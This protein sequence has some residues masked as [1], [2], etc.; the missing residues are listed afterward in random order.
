MRATVTTLVALLLAL[1]LFAGGGEEQ[2]AAA[3]DETAGSEPM[4][5]AGGYLEPPFLAQRVADGELPPIDERLPGNPLVLTRQ[6]NDAPDGILDYQD[7][8]YGGT[9]RMVNQHPF[10]TPVLSFM[11]IEQLLSRPGYNIGDP[12]TGNVAES[13]S[14]NDDNTEFTF[15]IREGLRWSDGTPVTTEDVRY[16][17]EDFFLNDELNTTYFIR[18][19]SLKAGTRDGGNWM[20]VQVVDDRTFKVVFDEPTPGFL[21]ENNKPWKGY[22]RFLNPSHYLKQYHRS[23]V[24]EEEL[25]KLVKEAGL[26]NIEDWTKMYDAVGTRPFDRWVPEII[27][28]P[29]LWP[30]M[31]VESSA[32]RVVFERNPYYYKVDGSGKQIPYIDRLLLTKIEDGEAFNLKVI[33]GEVDIDD[34]IT[35]IDAIPLYAENAER[36]GYLVLPMEQPY[37]RA[38][39]FF[40]YAS[41]DPLW[42]DTVKDRRFRLALTHAINSQEV[43]DT[44]YYGF[45]APSTWV[46]SDYDPAAAE[47]LLDEIGLD[48]RDA[49]GWRLQADGSRLEIF[50]SINPRF[51]DKIP[52]AELLT[53]YF[54]AVGL[55]AT[56]KVQEQAFHGE[57]MRANK[58]KIALESDESTTLYGFGHV[59]YFFHQGVPRWRSW[60]QTNGAEGEEPDQWWLD[61]YNLGLAMG[62]GIPWSD[63]ALADFKAALYQNIPFIPFMDVP[64]QPVI[65]NARLG[66]VF[67]DGVSQWLLYAGE[68]LYFK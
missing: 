63:Q 20:D 60:L 54:K 6:R 39:V 5:T 58:L 42:N 25:L 46:P 16:T 50:F 48:K 37:N 13:W 26:E 12:L 10:N 64:K 3:A 17:F 8:N 14:A 47:A 9:L 30:W 36:G 4:A 66:N 52:T 35:Q 23:Y 65:V 7:G 49:Q 53:E 68:Q 21:D 55:F 56:F 57:Q 59:A 29:V 67:S 44:V 19:R 32:S 33:A 18:N 27:G 15:T 62:P 51:P 61:V 34:T 43:A 31:V 2:P 24:S 1:P 41:E 11:L 40:N 45:A 28:T 22:E 38:T